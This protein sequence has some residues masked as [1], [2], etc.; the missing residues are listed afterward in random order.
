LKVFTFSERLQFAGY[1]FMMYC[2]HLFLPLQLSPFYP[3]ESTGTHVQ[4]YTVGLVFTIILLLLAG[5]FYKKV[6]LS[7]LE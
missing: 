6:K 3:Y 2:Y 5:V 4:F 1:G 7:S